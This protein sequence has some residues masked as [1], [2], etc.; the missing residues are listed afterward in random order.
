MA[1]R[2]AAIP[3]TLSR[4]SGL[5]QNVQLVT[6]SVSA[7]KVVLDKVPTNDERF[8]CE[9]KKYNLIL[10]VE[11]TKLEGNITL[12]MLDY[13]EELRNG[14]ISTNV[15]PVLTHGVET[16]KSQLSQLVDSDDTIEM[17]IIKNDGT[18]SIR[19]EIADE[20]IRNVY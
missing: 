20:Q 4:C 3:I 11:G 14:V 6:G 5:Y 13:F 16:I 17:F 15:D 10:K 8:G 19:I 2:R 12:P 1:K 18:S 7:K 9:G